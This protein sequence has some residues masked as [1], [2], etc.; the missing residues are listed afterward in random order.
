M[1]NKNTETEIKPDRPS[2]REVISDCMMIGGGA[3]LSIGAGMVNEAA[4]VIVAGLIAIVYGVFIA[5]GGR[6]E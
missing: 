4:G 3:L 2:R 1:K 5:A 6:D